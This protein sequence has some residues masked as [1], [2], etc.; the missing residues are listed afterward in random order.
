MT[1]AAAPAA[2]TWVVTL[3]AVVHFSVLQAAWQ[4][5]SPAAIV[6]TD[7][8]GPISGRILPEHITLRDQVRWGTR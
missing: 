7:E 6:P 3:V 2:V 5:T 1:M 4:P 8:L